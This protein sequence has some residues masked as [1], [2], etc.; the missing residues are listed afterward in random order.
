MGYLVC[1]MGPGQNQQADC[2]TDPRLK[3]PPAAFAAQLCCIAGWH[4]CLKCCKKLYKAATAAVDRT[5]SD[6]DLVTCKMCRDLSLHSQCPSDGV[7]VRTSYKSIVKSPEHSRNTRLSKTASNRKQ[8]MLIV[9]G[10][11]LH[12]AERRKMQTGQI[13]EKVPHL[14]IGSFVR[15]LCAIMA[16]LRSTERYFFLI[17]EK[18][19]FRLQR[20]A[21]RRLRCFPAQKKCTEQERLRLAIITPQR[22]RLCLTS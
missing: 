21:C 20:N 16:R 5:G 9:N 3:L 13:Q 4:R 8:R 17:R 10:G 2:N 11:E 7:C 18:T 15:S 14:S 19:K 12:A 1:C 22:L 6:Q